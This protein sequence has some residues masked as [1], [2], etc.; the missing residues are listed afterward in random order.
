MKQIWYQH[1]WYL[2]VK[3]ISVGKDLTVEFTSKA[4]NVVQLKNGYNIFKKMYETLEIK[5][6]LRKCAGTRAFRF[7]RWLA[8]RKAR[9]QHGCAAR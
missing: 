1:L 8:S 3:I 9:Y 7:D 4:N 2:Q 6:I 5:I